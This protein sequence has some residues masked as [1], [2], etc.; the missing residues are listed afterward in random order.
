MS[1]VLTLLTASVILNII[2]HYDNKELREELEAMTDT[3]ESDLNDTVPDYHI[4][5]KTH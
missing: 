3:L 5:I 1:L 4:T 2:Q